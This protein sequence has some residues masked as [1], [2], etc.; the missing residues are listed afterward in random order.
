MLPFSLEPFEAIG[1]SDNVAVG[2]SCVLLELLLLQKFDTIS[3]QNRGNGPR[4]PFRHAG[5]ICINTA[6]FV[7]LALALVPTC[8]VPLSLSLSFC[9]YACLCAIT[10]CLSFTVSAIALSNVSDDTSLVLCRA[11]LYFALLHSVGQ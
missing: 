8:V 9:L 7:G 10:L 11:S 5:R 3:H 1:P 6:H 4:L 2:I